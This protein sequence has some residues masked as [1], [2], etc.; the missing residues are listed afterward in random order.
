MKAARILFI[1]GTIHWFLLTIGHP[2]LVDFNLVLG[3]PGPFGPEVVP[4]GNLVRET[5]LGNTWD[6]GWLGSTSAQNAFAGYSVWLWAST[7]FLGLIDVVIGLSRELPHKLFYRL[8]ILNL[9]A[10][11][12]FTVY[13]FVFF[14]RAPQFNGV[15]G[16]LM[17]GLAAWLLAREHDGQAA[18]AAR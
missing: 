15:V 10:Y 13:S 7:F 16:I 3:R 11:V 2:I 18:Q 4:D 12:V 9:V 6:F 1:I 5:L 14:V 8:T 17:F